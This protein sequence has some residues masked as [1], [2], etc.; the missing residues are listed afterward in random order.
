MWYDTFY[1]WLFSIEEARV[2]ASDGNPARKRDLFVQILFHVYQFFL[3]YYYIIFILKR[4]F[5]NHY[6]RYYIEQG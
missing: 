6:N 4:N 2:P 3:L 1:K 5:F